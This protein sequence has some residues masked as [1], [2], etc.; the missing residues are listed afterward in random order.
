MAEAARDSF[1]EYIG[2]GWMKPEWSYGFGVMIRLRSEVAW[3]TAT[4]QQGYYY[5]MKHNF[6][7]V[8]SRAV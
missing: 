3:Q 6:V 2:L 4:K 5:K 8:S 1:F 7:I